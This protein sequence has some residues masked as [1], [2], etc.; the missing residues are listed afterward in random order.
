[1]NIFECHADA[2]ER[3]MRDLVLDY[4]D[5]PETLHKEMIELMCRTLE[6]FGCDQGVKIFKEMEEIHK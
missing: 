2:F 5:E 3:N 1:M 4:S 6:V